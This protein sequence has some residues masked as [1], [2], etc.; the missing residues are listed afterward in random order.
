MQGWR[1]RI[2]NYVKRNPITWCVSTLVGKQGSR[3]TLELDALIRNVKDSWKVVS[4]S[5]I[6][7]PDIM[8]IIENLEDPQLADLSISNL[9]QEV[10]W[11]R[12]L[13]IS[14]P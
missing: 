3:V 12:V 11:R 10:E 1:K 9:S 6:L 13:E 7:L 5:K 14:D 2:L 4:F 8:L